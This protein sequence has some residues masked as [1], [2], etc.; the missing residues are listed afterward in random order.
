MRSP[1]IRPRTARFCAVAL[2]SSP[3]WTSFEPLLRRHQCQ[4]REGTLLASNGELQAIGEQ[5]L[6]HAARLIEIGVS[7]GLRDDVETDV[8]RSDPVGPG[9]LFLRRESVGEL[10]AFGQRDVRHRERPVAKR[11]E[12][13][14]DGRAE[15]NRRGHFD[16]GDFEFRRLRR[17]AGPGHEQH[18]EAS[19]DR[20]HADV[21]HRIAS[22]WTPDAR[23]RYQTHAAD[24]TV[25]TP[26]NAA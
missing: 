23:S 15:A 18:Q 9:D 12:V 26:E 25:E 13:D 24:A 3:A 17:H 2:T 22:V 11:P 4:E 1:R 6:Q 19:Q 7:H 8:S 16:R 10:D 5:R 21:R 14:G 20:L